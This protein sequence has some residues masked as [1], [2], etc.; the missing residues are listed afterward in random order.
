MRTTLPLAVLAAALALSPRAGAA[1]DEAAWRAAEDAILA[2]TTGASIPDRTFRITDYG[3]AT[4]SDATAAINRAVEACSRAGGG[5]VVV[6]AGT[7]SCG[8]IRLQSGVDLHLDA[9][10]VLR[11]STDPSAYPVV[12]SRFEGVECMN[13]ASLIHAVGAHD[14]SVTGEG[15][16]DGQADVGNWWGW[17]KLG[18]RADQPDRM[19]LFAMGERGDPVE[20]RVFGMGHHL[21]PNFIDLVRCT[22]ITISGV[23]IRN[24]PMWEIHPVLSSN[25]VVKGV[26]ILS[27]GPNNDGCDPECCRD[28]LIEGCTFDTGDDCIAIKSGRNNDG[29]RVGVPSENLV[30]R[31]CRMRDGHGGVVIGSEISG[32]CRGVYAEDCIMDS[33]R[34]NYALRLKSNA[35]RGGTLENIHMWNV[36][37]GSVSDAVL[38]V[39]LLYDEGPRGDFPPTVRNVT[40]SHVQSKDSPHVVT[41]GA[42]PAASVTDIRVEDCR[43]SGV[44]R[45]QEVRGAQE[46]HFERVEINP[47][48]AGGG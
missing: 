24:S 6:P 23:H 3:A 36:T 27:H 44:E 13:F 32:G 48:K 40:V 7:W 11:F 19:V 46:A 10:A 42:F 18:S 38:T 45:A 34:L 14:I 16:L 31:R 47:G 9:G 41:I 20:R 5:H 26:D 33:P 30:I 21:R 12:P 37:I 35:T 4:G 28:V 43:F 17:T 2:R 29:R 25:I 1:Q 15:T 22:G 39:D 8:A